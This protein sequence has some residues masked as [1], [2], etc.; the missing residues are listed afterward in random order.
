MKICLV[1][2]PQ[3]GK[4]ALFTALTGQASAPAAAKGPEQIAVVKVPDDRIAFLS[5]IFRPRKKTPASIEF[6]EIAGIDAGGEAKGRGLSEHFL[7]RLRPAEALLCVVRAFEDPVV[8]HPLDAIDPVRDLRFLEAEFLLSD[9]AIV[10]SR[11]ERLVKQI[12]A[13]K[14][15][16]DI[17][18]LEVLRKCRSHLE[19]ETPLRR[20]GLKLEEEKIVRGFR[21][22]TLKPLIVAVNLGEDDIGREA[23]ALALFAPWMELER[24]AVI[25]LSARLEMEIRQFPEDE[26]VALLADFG[27]SDSALNRLIAVS[28]RLLG[29]ASFFTV[30]SDEVKAWTIREG[31][32]A[33]QAAGVIHSD[34]ERGFI[35]AEVVPFES[36][37][38]CRSL[39][40]CRTAGTLR[41]EGKD[42]PVRDGDIINF[43][44][45]I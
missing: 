42:Y 41:L 30:G 12:A 10:E 25:G 39:P 11:E 16:A 34:I 3:S 40:E 29:L 9:L 8:P 1:G 37:A 26:A 44:F 13:K 28:F 18:E 2:L 15:E 7:S 31:T 17:R 5:E 45:A 27:M 4:S 32:R 19:A 38:A 14:S 36:F 20:A 35:R 43:R 23:E 24:T 6:S 33:V 21:F 22:L